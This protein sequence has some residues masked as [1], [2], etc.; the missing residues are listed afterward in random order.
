MLLIRFRDLAGLKQL[1]TFYLLQIATAGRKTTEGQ[2]MYEKFFVV[3]ARGFPKLIMLSR[4][5][6]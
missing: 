2:K 5:K 1:L 3:V 4:L 6:T